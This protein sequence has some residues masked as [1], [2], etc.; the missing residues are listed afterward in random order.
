MPI[1]PHMERLRR[2]PDDEGMSLVELMMAIM[3]FGIAMAGLM[4]GFISVG[5]KTRLDKDRVAAANLAARELEIVR[6]EFNAS[7]SGPLTVAASSSVTNGYP[8]T[9]GTTGQ[10]LVVDNVPY[11]VIRRAEWLP[12]G[13]GQSPCDGGSSVTYPTLAV[14]VQVSWPSMGQ[15]APVESNTLLTPPKGVLASSVS[16]VA[17]KVLSAAGQG[18]EYIPVTLTGPGGTLTGTTAEDGCATVAV[19]T[20]G[21][22]TASLSK[23][24]WV[25]FYGAATP[26]KSVTAASSSI[27]RLT[28]NY[29]RAASIRVRL[30]TDAGYALPTG[31]RSVTLANTGLQ[32][33]GTAVRDIGTSGSYTLATLWPFTDGYTV[34]AGSCTQSDPA[35]AGG[36]RDTAVVTQPGNTSEED[37]LLGAVSVT[38]RT[39]G[40]AA[41]TGAAVTA[42][43]LAT[44]GC[45]V[46]ENP[47]S[48][49]TTD[50]TGVLKVSLPAGQW[51]LQVTGRTPSGAWPTTAAVLPGAA[52]LSQVVTVS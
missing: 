17:V 23:T 37:V 4:G 43:P 9:G 39:A 5:Q 45:A 50:A 15:V 49:G 40:G 38:V 48:L 12:A 46:S 6:N 10:P 21:T 16:F 35:T 19:S 25:D 13:T 1:F 47:L 34:W 7:S 11:T 52:P 28:F 22:Y 33:S 18:Q 30:L 3:V 31:L 14:N 24:G 26:S 44:A 36:A 2:A 51:T 42:V 32:P 20:A 8:L 29:D 41:V 27:A